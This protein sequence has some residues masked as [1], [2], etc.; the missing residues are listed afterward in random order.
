VAVAGGFIII[1]LY[2][3]ARTYLGGGPA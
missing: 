1:P 2:V 3:M